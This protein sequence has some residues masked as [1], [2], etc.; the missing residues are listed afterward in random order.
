MVLD[1]K[2]Q[3]DLL[4]FY[5]ES[6]RKGD[7]QSLT[8]INNNLSNFRKKF[9][10][11]VL[12]SL[13]G[14][15]LLEYM[16]GKNSRD[17]LAYWLEFKNDEEFETNIFGSIGGGSALKFYIYQSR[18]GDW[19]TGSPQKQ[20]IIT[21]D[22][23]IRIARGQREELL[24]CS[25]LM[26]DL[27]ENASDAEYEELQKKLLN[28]KRMDPAF[29][30]FSQVSWGHKYLSLL[31][32]SKLDDFHNANYQRFY[33]RKALVMPPEGV[34]R[35][36][37]AG[38]YVAMAKELGM[39]IIYL[40]TI[41]RLKYGRPY[42]Y[43]RIS[44]NDDGPGKK[45][46]EWMRSNNSIAISWSDI[47]DISQT[48][49]SRSGLDSIKKS[50]ESQYSLSPPASTKA[51]QQV[52]YFA[53]RINEGDLVLITSGY[54][55]LGAGNVIGNYSYVPSYELSHQL[56]VEWLS[57]NDEEA[58]GI[59]DT[60]LPV[61]QITSQ[62][63]LMTV[64][65]YLNKPYVAPQPP[66]PILTGIISRIQSVLERKSQVIL[67]G[68]PGTGK[69]YWA[70]KAAKELASRSAFNKS[71]KD[72]TEEE[73]RVIEGDKN[74]SGL[75]R[76]CT[77][78]PSF[79]YEDFIE[80]YRSMVENGQMVFNVEDGI[81]KKLCAE[82]ASSIHNYYLIID[83][84]N[85]GDTPRIFGELMTIMEKD[86]R[87]KPVLLPLSGN[88]LRVPPNVFIIG[89]MNTADKSISLLDA[90]LRR[91]FGFVELMP[92]Y[93]I[94]GNAQINGI[95]LGAW[96]DAIN[97]SILD[98]VGPDARNLLIGHTYLLENGQPLK[99]FSKF[100][101]VLRDDIIPLLEEYCYEDYDKLG[102]ILG[103]TIIDVK[104]Q[105][106]NDGLFDPSKWDNL[107]D[108]LLVNYPDITK[109]PQAHDSTGEEEQL[110]G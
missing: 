42:N 60:D 65:K 1:S 104:Q 85:R 15:A 37:C 64:E 13:D 105:R 40:T 94:L 14:K 90:A 66:L 76:M 11:E 107:V 36:I 55:I 45:Q 80:G 22:E 87:N 67:Y 73:K 24:E 108:A 23:A 96:L 12:A 57:L 91:R 31:Y 75:V 98:N 33:L 68:P 34:G 35:F 19:V 62:G 99:D 89:T 48:P 110:T 17:S 109:S 47:G 18:K 100:C 74:K 7:L 44:I 52:F 20:K 16:H 102:K 82:A 39:P 70:E 3:T 5:E 29:A 88:A 54:H 38:K 106:I 41:L 8:S 58:M 50:I 78:H 30:Y 77:F 6:V 101:R 56:P 63:T 83:E 25:K 32:P 21:E 51:A 97:S 71:F 86:K 72:L 27:P 92:D 9:N 4:Q 93:D 43:W 69:T 10:P 53:N 49:D 84:F 28:V 2:M 46:W 81:F 61:Y 103:T 79:G 95:P 26:G 59:E